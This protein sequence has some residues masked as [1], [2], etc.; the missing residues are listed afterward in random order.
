MDRCTEKMDRLLELIYENPAKAISVREGARKTGL[1]KSTVQN[2]IKFLKKEGILN[3]K[4]AFSNSFYAKFIKTYYYLN[5]IH[6]SGLIGFLIKHANPSAIILFGSF[7]KGESVAESDIDLF[8]E[9]TKKKDVALIHYER[10]LKH[11]IQL[12]TESD[13]KKLPDELFNNVVNGIKL[14]G[15]FDAR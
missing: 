10:K 9:A 8:V 11:E 1:S 5:K 4:G 13:I 6:K 12:F 2:K 15:Y 3:N 7:A 14:Y